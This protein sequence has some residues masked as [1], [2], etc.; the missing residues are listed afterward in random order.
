MAPLTEDA[1]GFP[2]IPPL[3]GGR[4]V[5]VSARSLARLVATIGTAVLTACTDEM[6][7][8]VVFA[9]RE[10]IDGFAQRGDQRVTGPDALDEIAEVP[11]SALTV[12]E[13][14]PE[15]AAVVGSYF[16]PTR[17]PAVPAS[18]VVAESFLLSLAPPGQR[19]CVV[20]RGGGDVGLV[21]V[22]DG[23]L[24]MAYRAGGVAGGLE[25]VAALVEAPDATL[26][27][28]LGPIPE[29]WTL[30]PAKSGEYPA[31]PGEGGPR[32]PVAAESPRAAPLS[33]TPFAPPPPPPITPAPP[34]PPAPP[35]AAAFM[36]SRSR[37]T[38]PRPV[39]PPPPVQAPPAVAPEAVG[40]EPSLVE[41]VLS[42][43]RAVL[44]PHTVRVED[45]FRQA[46]PTPAGLTAAADTLRERRFRLI[47]RATLEEVAS[48]AKAAVERA[49]PVGEA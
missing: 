45:V 20:V 19:G 9:D 11:T 46:E 47:S 33:P 17:L 23:R 15:L 27:A 44:G 2:L 37:P 49:A 32:R 42:E 3:P 26:W 14:D 4:E 41:V 39:P 25:Q 48:R 13:I 24:L 28:R 16:L 31:Q 36:A 43:V 35:G 1:D 21:F 8:A 38:S 30:S 29:G 40:P 12:T 10:P 34:P 22:A 7:A 5:A 18:M 6:T